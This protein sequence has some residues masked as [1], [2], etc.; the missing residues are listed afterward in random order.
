MKKKAS[1][2][3]A[4]DKAKKLRLVREIVNSQL[5]DVVGGDCPPCSHMRMMN[6]K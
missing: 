5:S 1:N 2:A 3:T 6:A 4:T